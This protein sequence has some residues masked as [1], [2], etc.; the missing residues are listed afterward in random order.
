M[1]YWKAATAHDWAAAY[2]YCEFPDSDF[3][4]RQMYVNAN[5]ARNQEPVL[6][7]KSA[8]VEAEESWGELPGRAADSGTFVV[9]YTSK[10]SAG[11]E[12]QYLT[13]AKTG[14]KKFLLWDEWKVTSS[15]SWCQNVSFQI[16]SGAT[17]KLNGVEVTEGTITEDEYTKSITLPYLF[18]GS[19]QMEV[20]AE[21]MEPYRTMTYVNNYGCDDGYVELHLS[22]ET[23]DAVAVQAGEDL[24]RILDS[25]LAGESFETVQDCF[26]QEALNENNVREK[27]EE[28]ARITGD[29][30]EEGVVVLLVDSMVTTP[31]GGPYQDE[32]YLTTR[33]HVQERY[34]QYWSDE[35]GEL[36][37]TKEFYFIYV[38]EGD[39][40]KLGNMPVEAYYF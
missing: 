40:W 12:S 3:L 11:E 36:D 7:Y 31:D 33:A 18:V 21:G 37:G 23:V 13:L 38:K 8:R 6:Q 26:S 39:T 4:T 22:Q 20:T 35:L 28:L 17:L 24:K 9:K 19:Y 5:A 25:A 15:D 2:D 27:Y 30:R 34:L 14:K 10:G 16:P 32:I 29:G 1:E